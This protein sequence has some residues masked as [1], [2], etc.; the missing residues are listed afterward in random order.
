MAKNMPSDKG[1]VQGF[2]WG[3]LRWIYEPKQLASRGVSIG[4][5]FLRYRGA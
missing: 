1:A 5:L 2:E 4:Y 3:T